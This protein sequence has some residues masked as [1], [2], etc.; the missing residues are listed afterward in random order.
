MQ[1]STRVGVEKILKMAGVNAKEL[2]AIKKLKV[3]WLHLSE[4][5]GCSESFIRGE[6]LTFEDLIFDVIDLDYHETFMAASG[7]LADELLE[8]DDEFVLLVEGAISEDGYF[9]AGANA[10]SSKEH[11]SH[12]AKKAKKIFAIG[13]CSSYGGIQAAKPNPTK[14]VGIKEFLGCD[15]VMIP[16]CPPSDINIIATLVC[17]AYFQ[18]ELKLTEDGKPAFAYS[19]C[20]H[21]MCERKVAFES[22][23]FVY[24]FGDENAKNGACLFYVGCKG[25]YTYNNCPKT[26]FNS[27][28]SWPVRGGHGCLACSENNFWD[29]FKYIE[30]PLRGEF[31]DKIN[32]NINYENPNK[33]DKKINIYANGVYNEDKC[34]SEFNFDKIIP[35]GKLG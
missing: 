33:W 10:L 15:V 16:G 28:T 2:P 27:K 31:F 7:F 19:K 34:L 29:D 32:T 13:S 18:D 4:C 20:L 14:S 22:G 12:L 25:P 35:E 11:L 3:I 26:K 5:T 24:E 30:K 9:S 8:S 21:D 23:E 17:F 6:L 1:E